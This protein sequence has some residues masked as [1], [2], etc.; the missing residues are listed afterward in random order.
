MGA[1]P[2]RRT[3]SKFSYVLQEFFA[4]LALLSTS[5]SCLPG[6]KVEV[7][8]LVWNDH[9]LS[10]LPLGRWGN[11]WEGSLGRFER[12][13]VQVLTPRHRV[14][15]LLWKGISFDLSLEKKKSVSFGKAYYMVCW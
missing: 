9:N 10:R 11:E 7:N 1:L 6:R 4:V 14:E 13:R 3:K 8:L 12:R 5:T 15:C 2:E